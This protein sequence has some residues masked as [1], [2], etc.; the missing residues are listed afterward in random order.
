VEIHS[1]LLVRTSAAPIESN[2]IPVFAIVS[3]P[4]LVNMLIVIARHGGKEQGV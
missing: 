3:P 4:L 1:F 2:A